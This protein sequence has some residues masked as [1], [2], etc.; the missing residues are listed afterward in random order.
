MEKKCMRCNETKDT[1]LFYK[2]KHKK[3]WITGLL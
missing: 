3:R 2:N 1:S